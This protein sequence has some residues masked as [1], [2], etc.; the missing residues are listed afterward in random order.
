MLQIQNAGGLPQIQN[1]LEDF[2]RLLEEHSYNQ[3]I[4]RF[5]VCSS[6]EGHQFKISSLIRCNTTN[7][8]YTD[9]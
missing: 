4:L 9:G 1:F 6:I 7:I 8:Q 2:T 5:T 3:S